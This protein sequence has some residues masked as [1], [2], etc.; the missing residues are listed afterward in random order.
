MARINTILIL[1]VLTL[2]V[3]S[4]RKIAKETTEIAAKEITKKSVK[5][6][7]KITAKSFIKEFAIDEKHLKWIKLLDEKQLEILKADLLKHKV[8]KEKFL[9]NPELT[10]AYRL[11]ID[12]P[13]FRTNAKYLEDITKQLKAN[14]NKKPRIELSN[15]H[16]KE[17]AGKVLNGVPFV[18]KTLKKDGLDIVGVF[19]DFSKYRAFSHTLAKE[20]YLLEDA[21]QFNIAKTAFTNAYKKNPEKVKAMLRKQNDLIMKRDA[22][23]LNANKSGIYEAEKNMLE[24]TKKGSLEDE[25]FWLKELRNRTNKITFIDVH[26]GKP[27]KLY[28]NQEDIIQRQIKDITNPKSNKVFGFIWHHSEKDGVL[29]LVT[30]NAHNGVKHIGGKQTWGGGVHHR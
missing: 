24:A 21:Q 8:F 11:K 13:A 4:C 29:E 15:N 14:P 5:T 2:L 18:K 12:Y 19:P 22:E 17:Q 3:S 9:K 10:T 25:K 6:G 20:Q 23:L 26:K 27:L 28:N 7:S 1:S 16:N 30:Q